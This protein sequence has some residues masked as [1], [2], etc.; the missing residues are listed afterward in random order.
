MESATT[1][2]PLQITLALI[3][4]QT[5]FVL[6]HLPWKILNQGWTTAV[7]LDLLFSVFMNGIIYGL[8]YLRTENLFFVMFVHAF[9]NAPTSLFISY[10]N[11]SNIFLLFAIIW[12]V[13]WPSLRRWEKEDTT[14]AYDLISETTHTNLGES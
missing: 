13:I 2:R 6:L 12:A 7:L 14:T 1:N 8:L 4:S 5:L 11:P 3:L 10:L 9:G